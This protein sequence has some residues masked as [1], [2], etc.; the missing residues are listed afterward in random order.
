MDRPS[1]FLVVNC[2]AERCDN[3]TLG[4]AVARSVDVEGLPSGQWMRKKVLLD[5]L[6]HLLPQGTLVRVINDRSN[7]IL[8]PACKNNDQA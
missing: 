1:E 4:H 8:C 5:L 2:A 3:Y 7:P 6:N